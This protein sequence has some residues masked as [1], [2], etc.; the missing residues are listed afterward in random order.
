MENPLIFGI[1]LEK[2]ARGFFHSRSGRGRKLV[3]SEKMG[4]CQKLRFV[5]DKKK[6]LGK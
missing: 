1:P 3:R 5:A 6:R 2:E 4:K